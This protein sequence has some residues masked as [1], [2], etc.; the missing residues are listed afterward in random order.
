MI[1][2][3]KTPDDCFVLSALDVGQGASFLIRNSAGEEIMVDAGPDNGQASV[4]IGRILPWWDREISIGIL[5]HPHA[6]HVGGFIKVF[7]NYKITKFY[8]PGVTYESSYMDEL[9]PIISAKNTKRYYPD[10]ADTINLADINVEFL[11]PFESKSGEPASENVNNDSLVMKIRLPG[12]FKILITGD[13]EQEVE[14]LLVDAGLDLTANIFLA[15]HHG[16]ATSSSLELLN[17]IQPEHV[18]IQSGLGNKFKHPSQRTINNISAVGAKVWR[19]DLQG[20]ITA[21]WC[22]NNRSQ[23]W[24]PIPH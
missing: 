14:D 20:Q 24:K 12:D 18:I 1:E 7:K 19:T 10:F 13:A 6:D 4:G 22:P 21:T 15:G 5:T 11:Y 9:V 3:S 2:K 17:K 8:D 23:V 16:S